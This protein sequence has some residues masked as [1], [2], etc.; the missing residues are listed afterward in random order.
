MKRRILLVVLA[1]AIFAFLAS[2]VSAKITATVQVKDSD[3]NI[4]NGRT[5]ELG[6][7]VYPN[8]LFDDLNGV[9]SATGKMD[10][11]FDDG[12]GLKFKET[13][14]SGT[15]QDGQTIACPP[16]SLD[17]LGTYEFR[18]NVKAGVETSLQCFETAQARTT[19]QLRVPEPA[20]ILG[21][22]MAVL[23]LGLFAFRRTRTK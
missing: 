11:Y 16:Y 2:T 6:T 5:I 22:S 4:L 13:I 1:L 20:T 15:V 23:G 8:G 19:I 9:L 3:G 14:W 10:V 17:E 7:T 12:T 18:W 21:L